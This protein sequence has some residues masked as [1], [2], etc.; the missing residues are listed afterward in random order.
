[1]NL[2]DVYRKGLGVP[3][4]IYTQ[5]EFESLPVYAEFV[6]KRDPQDFRVARKNT[7][8]WR[9]EPAIREFQKRN[10]GKQYAVILPNNRGVK[11]F[12]A[13]ARTQ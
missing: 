8:S 1:M 10:P 4:S 11:V 6:D 5:K 13:P 12:T 7:F 9:N 2:I 3:Q